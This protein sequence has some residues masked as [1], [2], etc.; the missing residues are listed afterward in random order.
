MN[1]GS[2]DD[3]HGEFERDWIKGRETGDETE[4]VRRFRGFAGGG[5]SGQFR[6]K[7]G[8]ACANPS[9]HLGAQTPQVT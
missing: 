9:Q 8:A 3:L 1:E 2:F 7:A 5:K 6:G 4:S